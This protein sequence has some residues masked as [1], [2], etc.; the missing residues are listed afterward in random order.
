MC[1]SSSVSRFR[2]RQTPQLIDEW[3]QKGLSVPA[4]LSDEQLEILERH[5]EYQALT[6]SCV[7][8]DGTGSYRYNGEEFKCGDDAY[9]HVIMRLVRWYWLHNIPLQYQQLRWEDWPTSPAHYVEARHAIDS[10]VENFN[11]YR[12]NGVGLTFYSKGLGT[13]KT[14][15][16]TAVLKRLVKEGVDGW[17]VPFNEVKNYFEIADVER[18]EFLIDKVRSTPLLVLDEVQQPWSEASK[19]FFADKLE[20]LIRPRTN[21]NLPTI[22]TTNMTPDELEETYPRV[23][24]LLSMKN[25]EV[26]LAGTDARVDG[27][28][29]KRQAE[30]AANGERLPID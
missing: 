8:C 4:Y 23:F 19:R 30:T 7:V 11:G 1:Y 16:A 20:E 14:W 22:I 25:T 3:K 21:A 28:V 12:L 24:S 5:P 18:K 13:G 29:W 26:K 2:E 17:F 9:G 10:Y 27:N 15:A 6:T